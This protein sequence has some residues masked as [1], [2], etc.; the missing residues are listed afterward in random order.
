MGPPLSSLQSNLQQHSMIIEAGKKKRQELNDLI[1][2]KSN[3]IEELK[4]DEMLSENLEN[5]NPD[6]RWNAVLNEDYKPSVYPRKCSKQKLE[7]NIL[8]HLLTLVKK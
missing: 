1:A 8:F 3:L 6:Q 2:Q 7:R 4:S 5:I